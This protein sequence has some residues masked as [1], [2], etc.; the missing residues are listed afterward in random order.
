MRQYI[1]ARLTSSGEFHN[2][3][4]TLTGQLAVIDTQVDLGHQTL[5]V[6]A[7]E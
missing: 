2:Y 1:G 4:K 5:D 6:V 7:F 3:S